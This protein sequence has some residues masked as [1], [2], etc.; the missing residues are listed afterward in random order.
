MRTCKFINPAIYEFIAMADREQL[1]KMEEELSK[2]IE[3][4]LLTDI[5]YKKELELIKSRLN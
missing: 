4:G 1:T 2:E 5:R 3:Q